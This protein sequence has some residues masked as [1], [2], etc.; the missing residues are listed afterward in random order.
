MSLSFSV[1][2][3]QQVGSLFSVVAVPMAK[4]SADSSMGSRAT[5]CLS[6]WVKS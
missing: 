2:G 3:A 4:F 5:G 1:D 6:V